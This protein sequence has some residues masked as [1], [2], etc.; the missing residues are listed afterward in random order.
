MQN[1]PKIGFGCYELGRS[2]TTDAVKNALQVGYRLIDTAALY[3]NE[4]ETA[5]GIREFLKEN[6]S[7]KREEIIYVSKLWDDS[8]G[9]RAEAGIQDSL[10][11]AGEPIDLYLMHSSG[12]G[13]SEREATWKIFEQKVKE[14]KFKHIGVSNWGIKHLQELEEYAEI[15]PVVNQIEVNPWKQMTELVD[16]C[17]SKGIIVMCYSPL[18]L[19]K[20]LMD[21]ELLVLGEKYK[22]TPAQIQLRY[23]IERDIVPIPKSNSKERMA[24]NFNIFD[25]KIEDKDMKELGDPK[26]YLMA[27]PGWDPTKWA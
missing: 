11:K 15:M 5:E 27:L 10:D 22:K 21:P 6:P 2:K 25:F 24:E 13:R 1:F 7:V 9:D 16:Y 4:H 18:T 19:G 26:A 14:G 3:Y 8:F 23:L 20:A 12:S 17:H